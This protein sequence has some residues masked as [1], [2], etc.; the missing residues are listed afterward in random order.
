MTLDLSLGVR[1]SLDAALDAH[2]DAG[3]VAFAGSWRS[4]RWLE[5]T[6]RAIDEA[7]AQAGVG[8]GDA[9]A[10][11]VRNRPQHVAAI[12]AQLAGRRTTTMIYAAQ[13]A[14]GIAADVGRVAVRA[15]LADVQDWSEPVIAAAQ[16]AGVVGLVLADDAE[17]PVRMLVGPPAKA[18]SAP[19][20]PEVAFEILSSGTTGAPKR[21]PL[22]WTA[23]E[24][25]VGTAP[26][27]TPPKTARPRR[28]SSCTRSAASAA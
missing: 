24:Q 23:V 7:L 4:W 13:S 28:P 15:V 1:R 19:R 3:A 21:V 11:V 14:A 26:R 25:A 2:P 12:A 10:L 16:A 18:A 6:M 22:S 5:R 20:R 27:S 9:V 8:P 17:A